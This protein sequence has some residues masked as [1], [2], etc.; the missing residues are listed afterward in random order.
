MQISKHANP[1][2][3]GEARNNASP[4]VLRLF[5]SAGASRSRYATNAPRLSPFNPSER[6][7]VD[8]CA[9]HRSRL[10]NHRRRATLY[11][12][13]RIEN[14]AGWEGGG[15]GKEIL[16]SI[17]LNAHPPTH[18]L[19]NESESTFKIA[20]RSGEIGTNWSKR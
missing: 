3:R 4:I 13:N 12:A 19:A 5:I 1:V 16:K 8:R 17:P 11:R 14:P 6:C 18:S 15:G 9:H 2:F 10:V 20:A 7:E